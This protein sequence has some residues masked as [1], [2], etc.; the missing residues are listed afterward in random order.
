MGSKTVNEYTFL[1]GASGL[2]ASTVAKTTAVT[3]TSTL[4]ALPVQAKHIIYLSSRFQCASSDSTTM[5]AFHASGTVKLNKLADVASRLL[6]VPSSF[7]LSSKSARPF[8]NQSSCFLSAPAGAFYVLQ[9]TLPQTA[10]AARSPLLS[11]VFH[12]HPSRLASEPNLLLNHF[13]LQ[14]F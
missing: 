12:D 7:H 5:S 8:P 14:G 11:F 1:S 4:Q 3:A 2:R 10:L 13:A 9:S 6:I